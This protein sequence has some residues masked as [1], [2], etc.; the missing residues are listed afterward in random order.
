MR[1]RFVHRLGI[2]FCAFVASFFVN[3]AVL[4]LML[5]LYTEQASVFFAYVCSFV[6][7][8]ALVAVSVETIVWHNRREFIFPFLLS[9]SVANWIG[10]FLKDTLA[11]DR[12]FVFYH[13][14]VL[15]P[16]S[17]FS[18]PSQ[19]TLAVF[20]LLPIV[21]SKN[22]KVGWIWLFFSLLVAFSRL[23]L[24]VHYLS[25]IILGAFIGYEVARFFLYFEE[26]YKVFSRFNQLILTNLE[27]RRQLL[28]TFFGCVLV[29]FIRSYLVTVE[30][31]ML[32]IV[33]LLVL[34]L[35]LKYLQLPAFLYKGLSFFEREKHLTRFPARGVFYFL[36]GSLLL[37]LFFPDNIAAACI[38]IIAFGDSVTNIVGRYFG[39]RKIW[40]NPRKHWEG[41]IAGIFFATMGAS[42]FVPLIP[43]FWAS[44]AAM[45][46]ETVDIRFGAF[47]LDDNI[48]IP[49][50]AGI[51]LTLL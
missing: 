36:L 3:R 13:L 17:G 33:V 6:C 27:V 47:E 20:S 37:L 10:V 23:Y 11:V 42:L 1:L 45:L 5:H 24:Q 2:W 9:F 25:D 14:P 31:L 41:T 16:E 50:V 18:L 15:F 12:P 28:H 39:R 35:L 7:I 38:M 51:V 43:A 44:V 32:G 26:K 8:M 48:T 4:D 19:H 22:K 40:Y 34:V 46:I 49:L 29:F 30:V 21:F